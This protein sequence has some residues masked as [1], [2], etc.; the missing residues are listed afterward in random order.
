M[1]LTATSPPSGPVPVVIVAAPGQERYSLRCRVTPRTAPRLIRAWKRRRW[2]AHHFRRLKP[3][4]A[5]QACQVPGEDADSS[6]L[7]VRLWAG[8]VLLYTARL[9]CKGRVTMEELVFSLQHHGRFL[10]SKDLE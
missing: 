4:W 7:V 3:L 8:L 2:I 5:T 9:L 6:Q 1:R 10:N